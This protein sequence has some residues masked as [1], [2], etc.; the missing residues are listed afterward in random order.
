MEVTKSHHG[1]ATLPPEKSLLLGQRTPVG[2]RK[3][4]WTIWRTLNTRTNITLLCS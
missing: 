1:L 4:V 3:S 2:Y